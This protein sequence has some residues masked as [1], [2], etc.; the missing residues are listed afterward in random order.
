MI[1]DAG[2]LVAARDVEQRDG[3]DAERDTNEERTAEGRQPQHDAEGEQDERHREGKLEGDVEPGEGRDGVVKHNLV[4]VEW[5]PGGV[6][7]P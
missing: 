5:G 1:I 7:K 2:E 3:D 4:L 6:D